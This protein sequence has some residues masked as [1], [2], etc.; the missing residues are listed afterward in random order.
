MRYLPLFTIRRFA[1][2]AVAAAAIVGASAKPASATTISFQASTLGCFTSAASCTPT[3][4]TSS[5]DDLTFTGATNSTAAADA[6]DPLS[7]AN[8]LLGTFSIPALPNPND[9]VNPG[10]TDTFDL[11]V[12]F[13]LPTLSSSNTFAAVLVGQITGGGSNSI[14]VDFNTTTPLNFTFTQN[15]QAG[16]FQLVIVDDPVLT[17]SRTT[18]NSDQLFGKI[19]NVTLGDG[20]GSGLSAVPEPASML[21]LGTG[22]LGTAIRARRKKN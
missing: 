3:Q 16:A 1:A 13:S 22:L 4:V 8:I 5:V 7:S 10:S 19:Q 15:G 17:G 11:L 20:A 18:A 2:V 12:Q 14:T 9:N 6:N 21:L